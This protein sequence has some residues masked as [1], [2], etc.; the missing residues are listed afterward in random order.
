MFPILWTVTTVSTELRR[1]ASGRYCC[2]SLHSAAFDAELVTLWLGK[3]DPAAAVG[4]AGVDD[5]GGTDR[6]KP[7]V[8]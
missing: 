6:D 8:T 1:S 3:H 2:R 4:P 5:Q 7:P